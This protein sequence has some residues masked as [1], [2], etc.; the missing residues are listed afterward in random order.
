MGR[1]SLV[2]VMAAG[3]VIGIMNLSINKSSELSVDTMVRYYSGSV[4]RIIA[5]EGMS[6]ILSQ[7]ADS[8][9]LRQTTARNL[10]TNLFA[11]MGSYTGSYLITN[12]SIMVAG[13]KKAAIKVFLTATYLGVTDTVL[14]Y[15]DASFGFKPEVIRGAF[16][17]NDIL[18]NTISDM[19]IDGR[20]HDINGNL[21]S[22]K[23][24]MGVSTSV[25]FVNTQNAAIG[26]TDANG[27]NHAPAYP[28]D[29]SIIEQNYNWGGKFPSN[30]DAAL[31]YTDGKLKA[32]AQSGIGGS[33]YVTNPANLH[34][35]LKGVTYV[36][37]P[38]NG[39]WDIR[40]VAPNNLGTNPGG[41]LIVHNA[42]GNARVRDLKTVGEV[43]PFK[44]I[45][46]ADYAFHLH[47][48][49]IGA[50]LLLSNQLERTAVCNG[51]AGHSIK[52]SN[53]AVKQATG[54][55]ISYGSGWQGKVPIIA[56][57]E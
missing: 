37:L 29:P 16:T 30:P 11:G 15:A 48:D 47:I 56:W 55:A 19:V 42:Q 17:A 34:Y 43:T 24:V 20:D 14:V 26:G 54:I 49:I 9:T 50:I 7:L 12:D 10:P 25:G 32:I 3:I 27:V 39:I 38:N 41:I 57:Q 8:S 40:N 28:Q 44:G 4:A 1:A 18:N 51:N 35:P 13:A 36:E 2:T 53:D 33:Q 5:N 52:Y 6:Y 31:G 22:T 23:G 45:V 46:I 21:V